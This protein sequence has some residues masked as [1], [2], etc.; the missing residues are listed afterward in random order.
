MRRRITDATMVHLMSAANAEAAPIKRAAAKL[1]LE[2]IR[3]SHSE[4]EL[5][6]RLRATESA[7]PQVTR[8][9]QEMA[10]EVGIRVN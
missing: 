8:E 6:A 9:A 10:S 1:L 2:C 4:E 7:L 3:I 5:R